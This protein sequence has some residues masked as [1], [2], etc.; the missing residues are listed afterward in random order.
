M[1]VAP[2]NNPGHGKLVSQYQTNSPAPSNGL[3]NRHYKINSYFHNHTKFG[4]S[5][6][7]SKYVF[8]SNSNDKE[9]VAKSVVS[10]PPVQ[11][12]MNEIQHTST[13]KLT[14]SRNDVFRFTSAP[15]TASKPPVQPE[16]NE[17]Q[18]KSTKKL[19]SSRNDVFRFTSAPKTACNLSTKS[20]TTEQGCCKNTD[21]L[22]PTATVPTTSIHQ[23]KFKYVHNMIH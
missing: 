1:Y 19:T 11:P 17:I 16:M 13:K 9:K 12:E 6:R 23:R 15:K 2:T 7:Q 8:V 10:K 14:S 5:S 20:S 3:T 22:K 4:S 18:H 21:D